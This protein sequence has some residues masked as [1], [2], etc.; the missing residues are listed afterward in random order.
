MTSPSGKI[1]HTEF[2]TDRGSLMG[3][4]GTK[5]VLTILTRIAETLARRASGYEGINLWFASAGD[6][7]LS[8]GSKEYYFNLMS[9]AILVGLKPSLD[10]FGCFTK[11]VMYCEQVVTYGTFPR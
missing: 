8:V 1:L 9:K 2:V 7:Q 11:A 4:P 10:K 6:D 5:I 3:E